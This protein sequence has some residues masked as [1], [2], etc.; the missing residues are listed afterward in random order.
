MRCLLALCS[1]LKG[2]L[3]F[4]SHGPKEE[5]AVRCLS[6]YFNLTSIFY[7]KVI[8]GNAMKSLDSCAPGS[9]PGARETLAQVEF[10]QK[11]AIAGPL[12]PCPSAQPNVVSI[13][14]WKTWCFPWTREVAKRALRVTGATFFHVKFGRGGCND[15]CFLLQ[16]KL[17]LMHSCTNTSL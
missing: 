6:L 4:Q 2:F 7:S 15:F 17:K 14:G 16:G 5:L 11:L 1:F 3:I 13:E 8:F 10:W 9:P 12:F